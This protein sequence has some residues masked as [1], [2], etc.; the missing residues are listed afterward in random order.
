MRGIRK[1][2]Q[3]K[4]GICNR[5]RKAL[6]ELGEWRRINGAGHYPL[7]FDIFILV[8]GLQKVDGA[9]AGSHVTQFYAAQHVCQAHVNLMLKCGGTSACKHGTYVSTTDLCANLRMFIHV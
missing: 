2:G 9:S 1:H 5:G 7:I 6:E 4:F 8:F 3:I